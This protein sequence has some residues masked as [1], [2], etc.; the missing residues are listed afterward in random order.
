[1]TKAKIKFKENLDKA[2]KKSLD[3]FAENDLK[4]N[5]WGAIYKIA[6][7]KFHK[8][9]VLNAFNTSNNA[10]TANAA[11]SL[12]FLLHSLLPDDDLTTNDVYQKTMQLVMTESPLV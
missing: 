7:E 8:M 1:M 10:V 4:Q 3:K 9:G 5:P 11:E 2:R 6:A 12:T